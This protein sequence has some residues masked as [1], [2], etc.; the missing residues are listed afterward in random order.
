[1]P[2]GTKSVDVLCSIAYISKGLV[3][4][5]KPFTGLFIEALGMSSTVPIRILIVDDNELVRRCMRKLLEINP[6]FSICGEATNGEEAVRL[7][8]E[9][10]PDCVVLDFSM[11]IMSGIDAARE[12]SQISPGVPLLMCTM[13][14]SDELIRAATEVGVKRVVSKSEK[15][16]SSLVD[17]IESLVSVRKVS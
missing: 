7:F 6:R 13:F 9:R 4:A 15:L 5:D 2:I 12:M 11:P 14:K 1:L 16:S 3:Q 10:A 17:T 8:R